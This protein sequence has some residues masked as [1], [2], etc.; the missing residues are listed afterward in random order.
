VLQRLFD[1]IQQ[2]EEDLD[3]NRTGKVFNVLGD[4]FPANELERML[5]EMY[6]HNLTEDIIKNR[7]VEQV[8]SERLKKITDSTLEGLAKRELNLS[9]IVGKSEE[10]KERRLVPEVVA[11]FFLKACPLAGISTREIKKDGQVYRIGRIPRLLLPYGDKLENRFGKL[12]REYRQVVFDKELLKKDPTLEWVTPG[13]PLY[14]SIRTLVLDTVQEDLHQGAVFYDLQHNEPALLQ[15]YSVEI[16]DGRGNVLHKRLFIAEIAIDSTISIRQPTIFLDLTSAPK[17]TAVPENVTLPNRE[18]VEA[19]LYEQAFL[20][21]LEEERTNRSKDVKTISEHMEISLNAIIDKAQKQFAS[22]YAQKEAGSQE[23]GLD[24]RLKMLEDK[25]DELNNRLERRRAELIKERECAISNIQYLGSAWVLPHPERN[26]P[27]GKAVIPDPKIE[28]IAVE[29]VINYERDRGW[30]AQSVEQ[31]NRGF[32][33]ISRRPHPEDP[34]TT[35][36][37]RFIEVKG[38]AQI[39]EVALSSNEYKTAQRLRKD[40]WL[41]TVF[42]CS[43]EPEVHIVQDPARL[44]WEPIVKI[45]HYHLSAKEILRE[46]SNIL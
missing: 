46:D 17:G 5:R 2:I 36:E 45:D 37:V 23:Q 31:E 1:R 16:R 42:N 7:I 18:V 39:G 8:D 34:E 19:S 12:G 25:L 24:G 32:D 4:V 10:A 11:E 44:T 9:A 6:A 29:A 14:E 20:P 41:Y 22:L 3:P 27:T 30:N 33:L 35:I 15:L 13:H 21:L 40:Y 43:K 28:R 26:T 38:R